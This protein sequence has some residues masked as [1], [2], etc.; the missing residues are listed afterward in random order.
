MADGLVGWP[1]DGGAT[2]DLLEEAVIMAHV[3]AAAV[4]LRTAYQGNPAL[5]P[6]SV[7]EHVTA[8]VSGFQ[9]RKRSMLEPVREAVWEQEKAQRRARREVR[10]LPV[11]EVAVP[12][13]G[14]G[15]STATDGR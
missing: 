10:R 6:A 1:L 3:E 5:C 9:E 2:L 7:V 14:P 12:D 4:L 15:E 11:P 13:A 8:L